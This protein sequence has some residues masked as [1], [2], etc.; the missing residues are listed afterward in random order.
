MTSFAQPGDLNMFRSVSEHDVDMLLLE[1][2]HS[3]PEFRT[4]LAEQCSISRAES[5]QFE[6]AWHSV[7]ESN[8]GES[9]L[10]LLLKS[11]G[12]ER[13]CILVENKVDAAP[14]PK[15]AARYHERGKS[16]ISRGGWDCFTTAIIAPE[17][18]LQ[19]EWAEDYEHRISY[20]DIRDQIASSGLEPDRRHFK[21]AMVEAAINQSRRGYRP[22]ADPVVT[23]FYRAFHAFVEDEFAELNMKK[24]GNVPSKSGWIHYKPQG[25]DKRFTLRHKLQFGRVDLEMS[26]CGHLLEQISSDNRALIGTDIQVIKVGKAAALSIAVPEI[27]K[28]EELGDQIEAA[29]QGAKAA[30][31]L[32]SISAGIRWPKAS[33]S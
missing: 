33:M 26:R 16:G 13:V 19:S 29:R 10:V 32:W 27:N 17:D 21:V 25:M 14:Q 23:A 1:E 9:D 18:Y 24:P 3:S 22:V 8:L 20:Q 30:I 12:G 7:T 15:Q 31:R 28:T 5:H 6:G 2:I 4:W 11:P